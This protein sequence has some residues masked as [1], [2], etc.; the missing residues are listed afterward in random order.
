M[1]KVEEQQ[2]EV[3]EKLKV[4][5]AALLKDVGELYTG[6]ETLGEHVE[7]MQD[8]EVEKMKR[9]DAVEAGLPPL[10]SQME[11]LAAQQLEE[12]VRSLEEE[13][14]SLAGGLVTLQFQAE[15]EEA[16][17][18]LAS[19]MDRI[20]EVGLRDDT[21]GPQERQ[22]SEARATEQQQ[23][24]VEENTEKLGTLQVRGGV[25]TL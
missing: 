16:V 6:Q 10:K 13:T 9:L 24:M 15:K 11:E 3:E 20:D 4:Q 18:T 14:R 21:Y 22:Q 12:R 23:R 1:T 2:R 19:R 25:V 7:K 8:D 5:V 17:Q